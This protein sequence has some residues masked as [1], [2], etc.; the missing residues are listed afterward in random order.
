MRNVLWIVLTILGGLALFW[1][2]FL[3]QLILDTSD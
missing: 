2:L 1:A 3:L